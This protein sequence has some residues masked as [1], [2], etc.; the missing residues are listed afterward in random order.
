MA[1]QKNN[2][3]AGDGTHYAKHTKPTQKSNAHEALVDALRAAEIQLVNCLPIGKPT[4]AL[5]KV[6]AALAKVEGE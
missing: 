4:D 6:R 1:S 5:H 2:S 3:C